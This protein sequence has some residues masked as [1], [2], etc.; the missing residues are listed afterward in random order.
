MRLIVNATLSISATIDVV[1]APPQPV[2]DLKGTVHMSTVTL[3]WTDPTTRTDGSPLAASEIASVEI[4]D[5]AASNPAVPIGTVAGGVGT[6][7][8]G[9]LTVGVHTFTVEVTDTTGHVSGASNPFTATIAAT[10][11]PPSAVANL[12]GTVNP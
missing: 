3:T 5:S 6:F 2:T 4:F 12:T 9:T 11:A 8:T 10:L 7:V 1:E